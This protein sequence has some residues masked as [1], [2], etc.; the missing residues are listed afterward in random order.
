MLSGDE[1]LFQPH[2]MVERFL[3]DAGLQLK[4]AAET[5]AIV[6]SAAKV[7]RSDLP[8]ITPRLLGY[9]IWEF[10]RR[11]ESTEQKSSE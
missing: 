6:Q 9:M 7:L 1:S 10:R 8:Q 3:Q 11:S 4:G 5:V 2:R